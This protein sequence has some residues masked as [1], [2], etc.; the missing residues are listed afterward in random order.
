MYLYFLLIIL[1]L[2]KLA[3]L[4][5]R[6]A[7]KESVIAEMQEK[8]VKMQERLLENMAEEPV[9]DVLLYSQEEAVE[10][11]EVACRF[12]GDGCPYTVP[13]IKAHEQSQCRSA[14]LL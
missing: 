3:K 8:L 7:E 11:P 4:E 10:S 5:K 12:S 2:F 9:E 1:A 14:A 6:L 13:S